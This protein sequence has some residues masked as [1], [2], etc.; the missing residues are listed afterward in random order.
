MEN[1]ETL[2]HFQTSIE[3]YQRLFRLEPEIVA[4]DLHP[5]YLATSYALS[6]GSS[7]RLVPVQHHHAHIVSCMVDN[8][9]QEP[10]IG[11][12]L[13]GTGYGLDCQIWG[14]E[15]LV[16]DYEGFRR[17]GFLGYVP[18]PGGEAAIR[19]PY[20]MAMGHLLS[21]LGDEGLESAL[22]FLGEVD[23]QEVEVIQ[24]QI[25]RRINTPLTSSCG[26]LFDAVS[27]VLGFHGAASYEGQAAIQ[28]E[29][30]ASG[31]DDGACYPFTVAEQ[32]EARVVDVSDTWDGILHDLHAGL[33]AE[34]IASRFH[35]TIAQ[36]IVRTCA[37]ISQ[38]TGLRSV[39]LS[40][41][42]FQNRLLLSKATHLLREAGFHVLTHRQVPC[43]DGGVSL[44]QAV[45]AHCRCTRETTS[46]TT[47]R[48]MASELLP[49]SRNR[50]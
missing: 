20:R 36:M 23:P 2:E 33:A 27:A 13:D 32:D 25:A 48:P 10:L 8:A 14:G 5:E 3:L 11:V 47:P 1:L 34:V 50:A 39:A 35:N 43:N 49:S 16:A 44:G 21:L 15:F 7:K 26:R 4:Y 37:G 18:L 40:G 9:V 30:M 46:Q 41:G 45:I 24:R 42:C 19:S 31:A 29:M 12:A 38:D 22:P 28:L 6:L 17:A